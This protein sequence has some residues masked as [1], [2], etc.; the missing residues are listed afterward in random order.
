MYSLSSRYSTEGKTCDMKEK[1]ED[2]KEVKTCAQCGETIEGKF[3]L[4]A[5]NQFWHE[6]C[7]RCSYCSTQ[8]TGLS[9][10]FYFK[11]DLILCK[12]DYIR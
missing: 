8:L 11:S 12:R 9:Y 2:A 6:E 7:L 5:L 1:A 4:Q 10:K 3:L